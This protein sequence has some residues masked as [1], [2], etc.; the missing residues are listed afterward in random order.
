[1]DAKD[2][3]R[4][5]AISRVVIGSAMKVHTALGAGLLES[6]YHKCLCRQL[7]VDGLHVQDQVR[8]PIIYDGIELS[9]AYWIDFII[10]NR[11]VVEIKSVETVL[12]VHLAQVLSYL[13][14]SGHKLGLLI[15]FNVPHLRDGIRR[16][17]NGLDE[18]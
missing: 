7:V 15:N 5:N 9:V 8:M 18:P 3:Q 16:I 14:L 6:A 4:T 11:L 12:P 1:M 13:R 2:A 10:E 17:V